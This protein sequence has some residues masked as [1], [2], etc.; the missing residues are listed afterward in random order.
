MY[1]T[2]KN[3]AEVRDHIW[4]MLGRGAADKKDAFQSL[5]LSTF[6]GERPSTRTVILRIFLHENRALVC[7]SDTRAQKI[8]EIQ[9]FPQVCWMGWHPKNKVQLRMYGEAEVHLSG[10]F[11]ESEWEKLSGSSRLNYSSL[12]PPATPISEAKAGWESYTSYEALQ[13]GED[14]EAWKK[15]FAVIRM[16]IKEIDYL[17]L[18]RGKHMRARFRWEENHLEEQWLIP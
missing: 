18:E 11:H 16:P 13:E 7:H 5:Y 6:D 10:S 4:Q 2:P 8:K 17:R 15:H 9:A 1:S 3:L 14:S 12:R